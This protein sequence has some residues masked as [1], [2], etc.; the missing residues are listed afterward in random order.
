MKTILTGHLPFIIVVFK[1]GSLQFRTLGELLRL[2]A[3]ESANA[4]CMKV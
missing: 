2:L 4:L 3:A 1:V